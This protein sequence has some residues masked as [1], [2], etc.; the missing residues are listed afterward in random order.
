LFV[1]FRELNPRG[2]MI[3]EYSRVPVLCCDHHHMTKGREN[4]ASN[5]SLQMTNGPSHPGKIRK[6]TS[7]RRQRVIESTGKELKKHLEFQLKM[8]MYSSRDCV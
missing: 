3:S 5:S 4:K 7:P 8:E 1:Y 2:V 6:Q